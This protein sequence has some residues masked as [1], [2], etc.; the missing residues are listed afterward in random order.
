MYSAMVTKTLPYAVF[1]KTRK[2]L[3]LRTK[4]FNMALLFMGV[5]QKTKDNN[6]FC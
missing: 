1:S 6:S 5:I 2:L 3:W 4:L